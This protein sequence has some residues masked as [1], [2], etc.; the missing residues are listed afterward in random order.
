MVFYFPATAYTQRHAV[1]SRVAFTFF[2]IHHPIPCTWPAEHVACFSSK[3]KRFLAASQIL[4]RSHV[5]GNQGNRHFG[6]VPSQGLGILC[7]PG[8]SVSIWLRNLTRVWAYSS[9]HYSR[10]LGPNAAPRG[11]LSV[12][13]LFA[14]L[15]IW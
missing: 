7:K 15:F 6:P 13:A 2:S 1:S 4:V 10:V 9:L 14:G 3:H 11:L 12:L 8:N 5:M